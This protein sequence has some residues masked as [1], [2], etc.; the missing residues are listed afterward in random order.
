ME[1]AFYFT[2]KTHFVLDIF[3]FLFWFFDYVVKWIDKKA[4]VNFKIHE[5]TNWTANI[6]NIYPVQYL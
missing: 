3:T 2:L 5:V 6:F 4:K 1:N